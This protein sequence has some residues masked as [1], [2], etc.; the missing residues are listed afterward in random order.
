MRCSISGMRWRRV[1]RGS[2]TTRQHPAVKGELHK[3]GLRLLLLRRLPLALLLL[4]ELFPPPVNRL[5]D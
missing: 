3:T 2:A 1:W 4:L 5:T